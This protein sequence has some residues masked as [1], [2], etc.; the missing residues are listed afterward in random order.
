MSVIIRSTLDYN[1][2]ICVIIRGI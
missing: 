2:C 1:I